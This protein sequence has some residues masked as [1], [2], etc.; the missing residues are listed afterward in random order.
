LLENVYFE[1]G[2]VSHLLLLCSLV[3]QLVGLDAQGVVNGGSEVVLVVEAEFLVLLVPI[4]DL[5]EI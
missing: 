1:Q 4:G 3:V 5:K 2:L